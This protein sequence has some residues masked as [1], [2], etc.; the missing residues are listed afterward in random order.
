[1]LKNKVSVCVDNVKTDALVDTGAAVSVMS[2]SFKNRLRQ[3]VMFVWDKNTTFCG[4]GGETLVPVGLCSVSVVIGDECYRTEFVVLRRATH[5]VILGVDFLR[6]CG[7]TLDFSAGEICLQPNIIPALVD[8]MSQSHQ[9][10]LALK[11]DVLLPA[12]TA[13]FLPVKSSESFM[14]K[15]SIVVEPDVS[16]G[17]KKNILVPRSGRGGGRW[18]RIP[19]GCERVRRACSSSFWFDTREI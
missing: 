14:G 3:K 10:V 6:E 1:M 13:T 2:L 7:A 4:V 12:M 11:E 8:N 19:L 5:D 15:H 18:S 9:G 17:A 16:N